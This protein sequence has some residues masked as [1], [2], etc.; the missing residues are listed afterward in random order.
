MGNQSIFKAL[1]M[2]HLDLP[3]RAAFMVQ[4]V[5]GDTKNLMGIIQ[6]ADFINSQADPT[7]PAFQ[8]E[9]MEENL[10]LKELLERAGYV[11]EKSS[12]RRANYIYGEAPGQK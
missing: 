6:L 5:L 4:G 10:A 11:L 8:V 12:T 3:E 7:Y 2:K 9:G 1:K